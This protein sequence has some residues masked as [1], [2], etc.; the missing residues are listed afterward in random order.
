MKLI[1]KKF[2]KNYDQVGECDFTQM[3]MHE[4]PK[5]NVYIYKREKPGFLR[6]ETFIAKRRYKDQPLPGGKVE[7]EDRECYPT[8]N[9]FGFTAWEFCDITT[10]KDKVKHILSRLDD[11][12]V[13][14]AGVKK[15]KRP[16]LI[17]PKGKW[18][19]KDVV[20]INPLWSHALAYQ[21]VQKCIKELQCVEIVPAEP[22]TGKG[23]QAI[24]YKTK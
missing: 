20:K 12:Q 8:A 9:H 17:Y 11:M 2:I 14:E 24:V 10:A 23:R 15:A 18:T 3:E 21:Q 1:E 6:F 16:E 22:F 19:M 7:A 13:D 5:V 4:T